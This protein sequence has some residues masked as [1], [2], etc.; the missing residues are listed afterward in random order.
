MIKNE[1]ITCEFIVI[2]LLMD[3]LIVVQRSVSLNVVMKAN[4]KDSDI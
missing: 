4:F 3:W 2:D 1:Q